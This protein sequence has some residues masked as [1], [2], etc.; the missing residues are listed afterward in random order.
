MRNSITK[1][2]EKSVDKVKKNRKEEKKREQ[3]NGAQKREEANKGNSNKGEEN[4]ARKDEGSEDGKE[5][6][7]KERIIS[8]EQIKK[9]TEYLMQEE[10]AE[11]T[12]SKYR[13]DLKLFADFMEQREITKGQVIHYKTWLLEHYHTRSVNS[14]LAA[15]NSFLEFQGF[16]DCKVKLVKIQRQIFCEEKKELQ[17]NEYFRLVKTAKKQQKKR[18]AMILQTLCGLGLRISELHFVTV[19]AVKTGKLQIYNKGKNRSVI[20]S[21]KL[22]K[23]LLFYIKSKELKKGGV[24]VTR[25]GKPV[26]RSNIWREMKLLHNEAKV[27]KQKVFPHNLRHL[28]A[29]T[30]YEMKKDVVRLADI[31]GHSNIETTR[32]YTATSGRECRQQLEALRLVL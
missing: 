11:A 14:M 7:K 15:V 5:Y 17:K 16:K 19:E 29:R 13:H 24:F 21:G 22:R 1:W 20:V 6:G 28:F 12:I 23:Q 27:R 25:S 4:S 30:Y 9:F 10:R 2:N 31:M 26:D 18:L 8:R 3:K 32:I